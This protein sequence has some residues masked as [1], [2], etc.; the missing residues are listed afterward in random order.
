MLLNFTHT[1][2]TECRDWVICLQ[3]VQ[4]R[5]F[6]YVTILTVVYLVFAQSPSPPEANI[7]AV[8]QNRSRSM[9]YMIVPVKYAPIILSLHII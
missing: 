9:H 1:L 8:P 3:E 5:R 7:V 2:I 4:G 6:G